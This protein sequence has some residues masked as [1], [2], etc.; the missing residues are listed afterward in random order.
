[1]TEAETDTPAEVDLGDL[2]REGGAAEL[3][4]YVE[5]LDARETAR[6]I[7]ELEPEEQTMLLSRLGPEQAGEVLETLPDVTATEA[8]ESLPAETAAA[9]LHE[10]PSDDQ[11]DLYKSLDSIDAAAILAELD[12]DEAERITELASYPDD[13]AGGLLA[14]EVVALRDIASVGRTVERLRGDADRLRRLDIQYAYVVAKGRRLVGVLRLRDLLLA[15][16]DTKLETIMIREPLSIP[17]DMPLAELETFFDD[18]A[19]LGVPV[20]DGEGRLVG[21]VSRVAV[22]EATQDQA[23]SDYRRSMGVVVEEL[24]T[25]PTLR[26]SRL[27]LA[28]LS[29]N[30]VLNVVAASVIAAYQETLSQVITL[31][32]FLPIISDMSGCSGNQAVAVSMRELSLG[33]IRP[34]EWLRVWGKEA[35][36]GVINGLALGLLIG[37]VSGFYDGNVWMGLVVGSALAANTLLA[38]LLGGVLPLALKQ[39]KVDPALASGPILTTVTDMCGFFLVLSLAALMISRL[40]G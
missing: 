39:M 4:A 25:M 30:I 13:T 40:V 6:A 10:L 12:S 7:C 8:I 37:L 14:T 1:M 17:A 9:I 20:V 21:A 28:W 16:D 18:H 32:V 11:A 29:I 22:D 2:V 31:A 38:V 23:T 19:F 3:A 26:R 24:R 15:E 34:N 33:L 5:E 35:A 27:R 36:V